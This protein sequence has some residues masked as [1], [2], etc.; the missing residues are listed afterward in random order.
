[1]YTV[2]AFYHF[3]PLSE[4]ESLRQR[5]LDACEDLGIQ[6]LTL[7][8]PE[9][10]NGTVSGRDSAITQWK[11]ILSEI[12]PGITFKDSPS[13]DI[14]FKRN[15]VKIRESIV[16]IGD[17]SIVPNGKNN[18]ITPDEWNAMIT[19]DDVIVLD[20]RNAYETE[21]GTFKGAIDPK[22]E[23]F[24]EFPEYVKNCKIPKD[25]KVLMCCT[26]GI[27]CEKASIEM[28]RQ[29]YKHVYQL[30]GGILQYIKEHPN[31]LFEGECFVFDHRAAVDQM[32]QPSQ[33][34]SL[35]PHCGDPGDRH[36][37]CARCSCAQ[38]I[39]H[40]CQK[41]KHRIACSKDCAHKLLSAGRK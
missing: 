19:S 9:G 40:R 14:A 34:Y 18:H 6:G 33:K 17:A 29:G 10:I 3:T 21:I 37:Q 36:I 13:K 30:K 12:A 31:M 24:Q 28:Q 32:L 16:N 11:E 2:T 5:L 4:L 38:V 15:F 25:K 41:Q 20:V 1:M 7:L 8:A 39:C 26:G 27:R 35:C 23:S 22:T